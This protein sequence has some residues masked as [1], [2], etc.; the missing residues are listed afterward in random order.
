MD[1]GHAANDAMLLEQSLVFWLPRS[2]CGI[3][4]GV[5][6][7][8]PIAICKAWQTNAAGMVGLI[9]QPMILRVCKYITAAKYSQPALVRM[10]V[11]FSTTCATSSLNA[12]S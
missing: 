6:C 2:E 9:A 5:G 7:R 4:P 11:M 3:S 1:R 8:C 10:Q 12:G